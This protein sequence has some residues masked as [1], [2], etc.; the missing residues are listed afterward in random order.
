MRMA[1]KLLLTGGNFFP[2]INFMTLKHCNAKAL[3]Y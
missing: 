1:E 2:I 3:N